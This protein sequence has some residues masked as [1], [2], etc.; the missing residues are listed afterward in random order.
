[1]AVHAGSEIRSYCRHFIELGRL[2]QFRPGELL[3]GWVVS[4]YYIFLCLMNVRQYST[5]DY[6]QARPHWVL[7]FAR[8]GRR[9][10]QHSIECSAANS[11]I[12]NVQISHVWCTFS[13]FRHSICVI[14]ELKFQAMASMFLPEHV[15][16]LVLYMVHEKF[17][18][19]G[20][21]FEAGAQWYGTGEFF[22]RKIWR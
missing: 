18:D 13:E 22:S 21:L 9:K 15:T 6:S 8:A 16:P 1:M 12:Q 11:R 19:T 10:I 7:E 3:C 5:I 20:K 2:W 14:S 4:L 17:V